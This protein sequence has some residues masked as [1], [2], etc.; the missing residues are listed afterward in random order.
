MQRILL[1]KLTS[2]GDLIHALPALSD[3]RA[4]Y[5]DI[6]FD[7]VVDENFQEIATWHPAVKNVFTTNH[8]KWRE[9]LAHPS[10]YGEI[11][12]LSKEMRRSSYD[13]IIDGQGNFKSALVALLAKGKRAGFDK[14][15]V[16]EKVAAFAYQ[17]THAVSKK[18]HAIERLRLLFGGAL[19]YTP[20]GPP[21]FQIDQSRFVPPPIELP[22]SYLVF[23]HN[24]T[25]QTKLWPESHWRTL[26]Q[27]AVGAGYTILLPWGNLEEKARAERL[28]ISSQVQVL[29]KLSLSQVGYVLARAKACVSMDTG[30]SHLSAALNI[31]SITLYGSTD[32]GLI[33][34]SGKGQV[35]LKSTLPCS[36]CNKKKCPLYASGPPCHA[37]AQITPDAVFQ[38]LLPMLTTSV[39]SRLD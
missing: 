9:Y 19:N 7:W 35:H 32:S 4:A 8:R 31:S 14:D 11:Y 39:P 22:D 20:S 3:A 36:P 24:A 30:L 23:V 25:W 10:T 18:A 17:Q 15:S 26:I 37:L 5:P 1:I 6:E 13:L 38:R 16:R 12:R 34:A 29:P 21:D 28:A 27:K 2:L 33:G